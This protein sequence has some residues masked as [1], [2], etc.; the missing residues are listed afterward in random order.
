M[1]PSNSSFISWK[2]APTL[3][4]HSS[5]LSLWS[6]YSRIYD[7]M[8]IHSRSYC[9]F[10]TIRVSVHI[11]WYQHKLQNAI[12]KSV[13]ICG[14]GLHSFWA[15]HRRLQSVACHHPG[16]DNCVYLPNSVY[17]RSPANATIGWVSTLTRRKIV[18]LLL[19]DVSKLKISH[20]QT[21]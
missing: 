3:Y 19:V 13:S 1:R 20:K 9:A 7:C 11:M 5:T 10:Y 18:I 15:P 17:G 8:Y 12:A 14:V 6:S 21:P 2:V 4:H 16:D